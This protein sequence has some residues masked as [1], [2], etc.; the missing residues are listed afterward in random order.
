MIKTSKLN[1]SKSGGLGCSSSWPPFFT[2]GVFLV[3]FHSFFKEIINF[4]SHTQNFFKVVA[5]VI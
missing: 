2:P 4:I 3:T 5:S 1:L